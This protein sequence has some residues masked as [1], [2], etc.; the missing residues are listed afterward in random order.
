[1]SAQVVD[2]NSGLVVI[3]R[4]H[5]MVRHGY[6]PWLGYGTARGEDQA[7]HLRRRR[8]AGWTWSTEVANIFP[9]GS[10][11]FAFNVP[12]AHPRP[13]SDGNFYSEASAIFA[14]DVENF[15]ALFPPGGPFSRYGRFTRWRYEIAY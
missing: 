15:D 10:V 1:M 5:R 14:E 2:Q 12:L 7:I 9:D 6:R 11:W 4:L 8:R 3:S 13:D